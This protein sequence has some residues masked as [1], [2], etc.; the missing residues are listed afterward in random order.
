ML[1]VHLKVV[2]FV[3]TNCWVIESDEDNISAIVDPGFGA[4][5]IM[6]W[7][8]Q[9][10]LQPKFILLTHGHLDHIMAAHYLQRK[11]GAPCFMHPK[12]IRHRWR[13]GG[14]SFAKF[15]PVEDGQVL[16]FG[17]NEFKVI[18]TPGH[19]PGSV[20]YLIDEYL[21]SGDLLFADGVGRWDTPKGNFH[22]LVKSLRQKIADLP[23]SVQVMP[24]HGQATTLGT[25]R[26]RNPIF[27]NKENK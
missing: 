26:D 27:W 9:L 21:F 15:T 8:K 7:V 6:E 5:K 13:W 2:G 18:R 4:R 22:D 11:T 17:E 3:Q 23:D 20:S 24:G 16:K 10:G 12:D 14:F 19:T 25:E 1:T